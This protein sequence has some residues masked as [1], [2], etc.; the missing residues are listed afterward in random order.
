[1]SEIMLSV[2][3]MHMDRSF[4]RSCVMDR[5][6]EPDQFH[7]TQGLIAQDSRLK[8][9]PTSPV[10]SGLHERPCGQ[11]SSADAPTP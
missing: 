8:S 3:S 7:W 11:K 10:T 2:F 1:M 9:G 6:I 4:Q 5:S